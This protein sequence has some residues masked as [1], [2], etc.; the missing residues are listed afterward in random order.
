MIRPEDMFEVGL[1]VP[2]LE[3]A[4][5]QFNA[6]FGYTFSP[7]LEGVLPTRHPDRDEV[8]AMRMAVTREHPQL[9]LLEAAPG[10]SIVPPSGT[11]LHHLGY[12]VDDLE[13]ESQRLV[14]LGIPLVR[15]GFSGEESPV[16]WVYHEM[17]DGTLLELVDR[18]SVPLRKA[19]IEGEVPESPWVTRLVPVAHGLG[20]SALR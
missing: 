3:A 9:E 11:G 16:N 18:R 5:E 8:P 12:Y 4:I 17:A 2:D 7:I 19:L 1:V 10:T 14:E 13:A 15:A 20:G 6:M